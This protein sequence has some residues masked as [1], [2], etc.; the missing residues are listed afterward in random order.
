MKLRILTPTEL[1]YQTTLQEDT[2]NFLKDTR[3]NVGTSNESRGIKVDS[4]ELSLWQKN[5]ELD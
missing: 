3:F 4:D 5:I 2:N 1:L